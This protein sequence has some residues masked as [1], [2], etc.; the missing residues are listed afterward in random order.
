MDSKTQTLL[1]NLILWVTVVETYL[2]SI[3]LSQ[4]SLQPQIASMA[5]MGLVNSMTSKPSNGQP[6]EG[7]LYGTFL[8][9]GQ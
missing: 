4:T 8:F 2:K 7:L 6:G 5:S 9:K 1:L 3:I